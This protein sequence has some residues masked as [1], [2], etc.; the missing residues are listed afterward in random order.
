MR[1]PFVAL[2]AACALALGPGLGEPRAETVLERSAAERLGEA[3]RL[4]ASGRAAAAAELLRPIVDDADLRKSDPDLHER[5]LVRLGRIVDSQARQAEQ[6]GRALIDAGDPRRAAAEYE[7]A[8]ALRGESP[9]LTLAC[10]SPGLPSGE[11][12]AHLHLFL[13]RVEATLYNDALAGA[14]FGWWL[15]GEAEAA[16]ATLGRPGSRPAVPY[17]DPVDDLRARRLAYSSR[18]AERAAK[19]FERLQWDPAARTL[20]AAKAARLVA[21]GGAPDDEWGRQQLNQAFAEY[22]ARRPAAAA[23]LLRELQRRLPGFRPEHVAA[24]LADATRLAAGGESP[25]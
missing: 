21:L 2:I 15:A 12:E 13:H 18:L 20:A 5:A 11:P 9:Y 17:P 24:E 1:T 22:N 23:E 4:L 14:A 3:E 19:L 25:R 16:E 10:L 7:R 6:H 8:A